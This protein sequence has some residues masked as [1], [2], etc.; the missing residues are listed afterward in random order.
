MEAIEM[1]VNLNKLEDHMK[2]IVRKFNEYKKSGID[3]EIMIIYIADKTRLPKSKVKQ[4]LNCQ[5]EFYDKLIQDEV[6][7]KI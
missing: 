1:S 3:E 6:A 5:Q 4:M 7:E 2:E